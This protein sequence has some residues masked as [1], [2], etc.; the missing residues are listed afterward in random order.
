MK[1]LILIPLFFSCLMVFYSCEKEQI[2]S[3]PVPVDTVQAVE[4][5]EVVP[6]LKRTQT[7]ALFNAGINPLHG[8]KI[9]K[10]TIN[11]FGK[12]MTGVLVS[13]YFFPMKQ[14]D[15]MAGQDKLGG[16]RLFASTNR[17]T[18]PANGKRTIRV[19]GITNG[20]DRL[21]AAVNQAVA[22]AVSKYNQLNLNKLQFQYVGITEA[23]ANA[24][25]DANG[26]IDIIAFVD[27]DNSFVGNADGRAT[28]PDAGNT[29]PFFG[30]ST[31]TSNYSLKENT[32]L[33]MHE[34]GH[35]LGMA[36][37][38]F[39]TRSTCGNNQ[40]LD[41]ELGDLLGIPAVTEVCNI[42]GTDDSGDFSNS[43]MRAC[44]FF[45]FSSANFTSEDVNA[46]K[47]LYSQ[48]D[49]PCADD[50][51]GQNP[52]C[53]TLPSFVVNYIINTNGINFYNQLIALGIVCP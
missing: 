10:T 15:E 7:N 45:V 28:F 29:G 21:P 9:E 1:K 36:H 13:D 34:I 48:V 47:K 51:P 8:G 52:N 19:G 25:A 32:I 12:R 30:L 16:E 43:I 17:V 49:I 5:G 23:E 14:L 38:D 20:V 46:F 50:G 41:P 3:V 37:A 27:S 4:R 26:P 22:A 33:A 44:G 18:L 35:T 11:L 42:T 40:P 6:I 2:S 31:N 53:V 39:L 24:G